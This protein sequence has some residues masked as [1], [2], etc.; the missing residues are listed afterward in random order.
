[1]LGEPVA[2]VSQPPGDQRREQQEVDPGDDTRD[3]RRPPERNAS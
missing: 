3:E 2:Q 1:V